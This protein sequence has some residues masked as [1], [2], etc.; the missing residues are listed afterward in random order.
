MD[1]KPHKLSLR[2]KKI[3]GLGQDFLPSIVLWR[4]ALFFPQYLFQ[5]FLT[6]G[7]SF[8]ETNFYIF[9]IEKSENCL[10][11]A[12]DQFMCLYQGRHFNQLKHG[13]KHAKDVDK[14]LH[15]ALLE[16]VFLK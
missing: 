7:V 15:L 6:L 11:K 12:V 10:Q 14:L 13:D 1:L 4:A 2:S 16:V 3:A 8:W 5:V 9:L